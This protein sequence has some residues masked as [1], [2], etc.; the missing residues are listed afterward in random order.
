MAEEREGAVEGEDEDEGMPLLIVSES[1]DAEESEGAVEG[2]DE[3]E[4]RQSTPPISTHNRAPAASPPPRWAVAELPDGWHHV[5]AVILSDE[6]KYHRVNTL[7]SVP[8][9]IRG[10]Y[11]R[12]QSAALGALA[13]ANRTHNE[14]ARTRAWKLFLLLPRLLLCASCRGP[15][16]SRQDTPRR[17]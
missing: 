11:A 17:S 16:S 9:A 15:F 10:P 1:R 13:K 5:D 7:R 6:Y 14:M 2:E 12:I 8:K 4:V 3:D